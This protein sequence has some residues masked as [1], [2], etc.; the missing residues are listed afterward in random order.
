MIYSNGPLNVLWDTDL[1]PLKGCVQFLDWDSTS[2]KAI[3][4]QDGSSVISNPR[5]VGSGILDQPIV[6]KNGSYKVIEWRYTGEGTME[7]DWADPD[8]RE[9]KFLMVRSYRMDGDA[10]ASSSTVSGVYTVDSVAALAA[11]DDETVTRVLVIGYASA[12]DS[13]ARMYYRVTGNY[14]ADGGS[15][16]ASSG[17][18]GAYWLL[19]HGLSI[20]ASV[21]GILPKTA[22]DDFT[23]QLANLCAFC[24]S[25]LITTVRFGGTV[26]LRF[27]S[28]ALDFGTSCHVVATCQLKGLGETATAVTCASAQLA[29]FVNCTVTASGT[30]R[31]G[32]LHANSASVSGDADVD[33]NASGRAVIATGTP[34]DEPTAA[35]SG[36]TV[37][38][39]FN[40]VNSLGKVVAHLSAKGLFL[41]LDGFAT[42]I[43]KEADGFVERIREIVCYAL[44][45]ESVSVSGGVSAESVDVSG[46]VSAESVDVSGNVTAGF[47]AAGSLTAPSMEITYKVMQAVAS[48]TPSLVNDKS[49]TNIGEI[50]PKNAIIGNIF[51]IPSEFTADKFAIIGHGDNYGIYSRITVV[52][53]KET[54]VTLIG[55]G[56]S[57]SDPEVS[58]PS[59]GACDFL[60]IFSAEA[61]DGWIPVV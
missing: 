19:C 23:A 12:G 26:P 57:S 27:T 16:I 10:K 56:M 6:L 46:G 1:T 52:N 45:A 18:T 36:S 43:K 38:G 30:V 3:Y 58:V 42:S 29:S 11:I 34:S 41:F 33:G 32:E 24:R 59:G 17:I 25:S 54:S 20:D 44:S 51:F 7:A 50:L 48:G 37:G 55:D 22:T 53:N 5:F 14:S 49:L 21:F 9:Q 28:S 39:G 47:L 4:A 40:A 15:V 35:S 31:F 13:P 8:V 61:H 2:E 60:K